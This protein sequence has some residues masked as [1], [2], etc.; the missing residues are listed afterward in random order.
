[1]QYPFEALLGSSKDRRFG[2]H[3]YFHLY[4]RQDSLS[5]RVGLFYSL[6]LFAPL[7]YKYI[8]WSTTLVESLGR[9][10]PID[11]KLILC[12]IFQ[13]VILLNLGVE[14]C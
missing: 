7:E 14:F 8:L 10:D 6:A 9:L 4:N 1:M 3:S 2:K 5:M 13:L 12:S 11:V